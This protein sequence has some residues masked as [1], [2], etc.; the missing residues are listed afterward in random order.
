MST[1]KKFKSIVLKKRIMRSVA[2][3]FRVFIRLILKIPKICGEIF[4]DE[5][6]ACNLLIP[7][8]QAVQ[9]ESDCYVTYNLYPKYAKDQNDWLYAKSVCADEW[10]IVMQGPLRSEEEFTLETVRYYARLYPG[11]RVIVSTWKGEDEKIIRK[12]SEEENCYIIQSD[13]PKE[14]GISNINYQSFSSMVGVRRAKELGVKY[15][16]KTR[17]DSRVNMPG[18]FDWLQSYLKMYPLDK[19]EGQKERLIFFNAYLFM[20]FQEFGMFYAGNVDDML[21]FFEARPYPH[22]EKVKSLGNLLLAKGTTYRQAF[23]EKNALNYMTT[24]YF[25]KVGEN[26]ACDMQQWWDIVAKRTI[27]FSVAMLKPLWP[28]YDYNH[29]ESD[30]CWI[31]RRKIMGQTGIDQTMIDFAWWNKIREGKEMPSHEEYEYLLDMPMT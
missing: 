21:S 6:F 14:A 2:S 13:L 27:C 7:M 10:G 30:M 17:T 1:D 16:L 25:A 11:V 9:A 19:Y 24:Q 22:V 26:V 5:S 18:I 12:L 3:T 4:G 28:K 29:E 31:Y 23:S 15:V 8:S 20:P